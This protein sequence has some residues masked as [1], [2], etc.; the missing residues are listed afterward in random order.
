MQ[1]ICLMDSLRL[2]AALSGHNETLAA[3]R[4]LKMLGGRVETGALLGE[5][6]AGLV[7]VTRESLLVGQLVVL[8]AGEVI[9]IWC[10]QLLR[11]Y[12]SVGESQ[13]CKAAL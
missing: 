4:N 3:F 2:W 5:L 12:G 1:R 8:D 11:P 6:R 13:S 10:C 9:I 7:I